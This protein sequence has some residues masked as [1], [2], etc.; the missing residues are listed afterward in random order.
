MLEMLDLMSKKYGPKKFG[1][2]LGLLLSPNLVV[3]RRQTI[4]FVQKLN[5]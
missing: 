5:G 2:P 4:H 3:F 1:G